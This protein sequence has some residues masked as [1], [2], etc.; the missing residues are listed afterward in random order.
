MS[1]YQIEKG[2]EALRLYRRI[3]KLHLR[4]MPNELRLFGIPNL[5]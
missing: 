5:K 2:F 3:M 4:N 1:K